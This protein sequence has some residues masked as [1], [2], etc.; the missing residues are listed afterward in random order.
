MPA[1]TAAPVLRADAHLSSNQQAQQLTSQNVVPDDRQGQSINGPQTEQIRPSN[2]LAHEE[3]NQQKTSVPVIAKDTPS[4]QPTILPT[5]PSQSQHDQMAEDTAARLVTNQPETGVHQIQEIREQQLAPPHPLTSA[6]DVL[7]K[8]EAAPKNAPALA[9]SWDAFTN[10]DKQSDMQ[11]S[12]RQDSHHDHTEMP[13]PQGASAPVLN[14]QVNDSPQ[15]AAPFTIGTGIQPMPRALDTHP[16]SPVLPVQPVMASHDMS[17]APMPGQ[18]RSVVFE[19]AQP[20]LGRVNVRVALTN[21]L[22]HTHLSSDRPDVGNFLMNGQDRL[23]SALQASGL[24]MGQFRVHVDRQ[25]ANHGGQEWLAR[26]YDDRSQQQRGN[27]RQ[28]DQPSDT[29]RNDRQQLGVLS[30]FA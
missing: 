19:V 8:E 11:G 23:Q 29:S 9:H 21:D 2:M 15:S 20:D 22:V 14:Q 24:E 26:E 28:Q 18:S 10:L 5:Q 25:G 3:I 12:D 6:R 4:T 17:D 1:L 30:V 13:L 16:S 7:Q 27:Q